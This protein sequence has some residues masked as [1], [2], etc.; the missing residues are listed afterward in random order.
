MKNKPCDLMELD[1]F[2]RKIKCPTCVLKFPNPITYNSSYTKGTINLIRYKYTCLSSSSFM[3]FRIGEAP[4]T[5]Y[6]P[7]EVPD[8]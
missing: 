7:K 5:Y 2:M 1:L 6:H 8:G 4:V 3:F